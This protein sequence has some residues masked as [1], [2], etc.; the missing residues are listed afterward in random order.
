MGLLDL[1]DG[2]NWGS[3]ST[4]ASDQKIQW[5]TPHPALTNP[6]VTYTSSPMILRIADLD[7]MRENVFESYPTERRNTMREEIRPK[8][9][10]QLDQSTAYKPLRDALRKGDCTV[11]LN[12]ILRTIKEFDDGAA[13]RNVVVSCRFDPEDCRYIREQIGEELAEWLGVKVETTLK[14]QLLELKDHL[15]GHLKCIDEDGPSAYNLDH[16]IT[17]IKILKMGHKLMKLYR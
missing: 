1:E 10:K 4:K 17:D 6:V 15:E 8:L 3:P 7:R 9:L 13:L 2:K 16:I 12:P 5:Y 11:V 14:D